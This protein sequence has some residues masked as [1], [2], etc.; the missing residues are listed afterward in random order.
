MTADVA[1]L[2]AVADGAVSRV[3]VIVGDAPSAI[4]PVT[5]HSMFGLLKIHPGDPATFNVVLAG[6]GK[7]T[8]TSPESPMPLLMMVIVSEVWSPGTTDGEVIET[9]STSAFSR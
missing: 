6:C 8:V 7:L 4:G 9:I 3:T 5:V 2:P 1:W